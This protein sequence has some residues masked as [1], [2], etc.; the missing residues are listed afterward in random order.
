MGGG[1]N[2]CV[3]AVVWLV[4]ALGVGACGDAQARVLRCV[5][6]KVRI[7]C[8]GPQTLDLTLHAADLTLQR[9]CG[10]SCGGT[11]PPCSRVGFMLAPRGVRF[12]LSLPGTM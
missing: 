4:G 5:V 7:L 1:R 6:P 3:C 9:G 12:V 2:V 10:G 11:E 8:S